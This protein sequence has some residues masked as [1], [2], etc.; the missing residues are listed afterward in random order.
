MEV[1]ERVRD[2]QLALRPCELLGDREQLPVL[3]VELGLAT[4]LLRR[5]ARD[6]TNPELRAPRGQ[7]RA[8]DAFLAQQGSQRTSLAADDRGLC[9]LHKTQLLR[10]REPSPRCGRH[11]LQR[12][13]AR[14]ELTL[15]DETFRTRNWGTLG[16]SR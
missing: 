4:R 7:V 15:F 1:D 16:H 8:V 13:S 5:E 9:G 6:T 3:R 2:E 10:R 14:A 11:A 12:C